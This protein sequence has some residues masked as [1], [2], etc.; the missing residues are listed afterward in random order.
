MQSITFKVGQTKVTS[1]RFPDN[2]EINEKVLV[3]L[4]LDPLPMQYPNNGF[5]PCGSIVNLVGQMIVREAARTQSL[6]GSTI[7]AKFA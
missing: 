6:G 5:E 1:A 2:A 4:G 3:P 7:G